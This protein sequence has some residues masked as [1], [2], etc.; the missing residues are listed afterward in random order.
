MQSVKLVKRYSLMLV[1]QLQVLPM[2]SLILVKKVID[3]IGKFGGSTIKQIEKG[4][5]DLSTHASQAILDAP[6]RGKEEA[7]K[8]F[9]KKFG[10]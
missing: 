2:Y 6:K 8:Y 4:I 7:E 9:K 1:L 10:L 5:I 3:D